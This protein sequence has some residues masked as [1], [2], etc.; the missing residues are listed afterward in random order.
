V[1]NESQENT[2]DTSTVPWDPRVLSE[3]LATGYTEA[4]VVIDQH[5][6]VIQRYFEREL[7]SSLGELS[8]LALATQSRFGD[9]FSLGSLRMSATVHDQGILVC[10]RGNEH[11]V[12]LLASKLANLG[13]LLNFV[14]RFFRARD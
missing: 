11:H 12:L 10:G 4:V 9:H 6:Q 8:E 14:R 1:S 3:I 13:Q 5:G 2:T 7:P